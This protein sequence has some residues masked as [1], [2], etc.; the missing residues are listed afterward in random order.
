[1]FV[2]SFE[3]VNFWK[4]IVNHVGV[5]G[6]TT[7]IHRIIIAY[8]ASGCDVSEYLQNGQQSV[9]C[10]LE[11]RIDFWPQQIPDVVRYRP[12]MYP[13]RWLDWV[14]TVRSKSRVGLWKIYS[15]ASAR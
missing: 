7:Y 1:M 11:I 14:I 4:R 8:T 3:M 10:T 13:D 2:S 12:M 6:I 9:S 15:E 5:R